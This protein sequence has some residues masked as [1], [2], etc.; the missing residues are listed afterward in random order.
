MDSASLTTA[1]LTSHADTAETANN[2]NATM[3]NMIESQNASQAVPPLVKIQTTAL[4][5]D[6]IECI[7]THHD[8]NDDELAVYLIDRVEPIVFAFGETED[9]GEEENMLKAAEAAIQQWAAV[10]PWIYASS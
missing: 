4:R 10:L 6:R 5:A 9:F 7:D 1:A 8:G 2:Q 3:E